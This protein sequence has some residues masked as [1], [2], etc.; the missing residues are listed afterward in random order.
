MFKSGSKF[1]YGVAAFGFVATIAFSIATSAEHRLEK[2][3][4]DVLAVR[5][6][7]LREAVCVVKARDERHRPRLVERAGLE[8]AD[9]TVIAEPRHQQL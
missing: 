5:V 8:F 1:L 4:G 3:R 7:L 2:H 9:D 6:E